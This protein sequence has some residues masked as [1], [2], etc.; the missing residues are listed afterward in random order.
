M[1]TKIFKSLNKQ[2]ISNEKKENCI[3]Q[4]DNS[5]DPD[6]NNPIGSVR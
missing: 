4:R 5:A 2:I 3:L 6:F 1:D